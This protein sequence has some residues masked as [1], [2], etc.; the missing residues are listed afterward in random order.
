METVLFFALAYIGGTLGIKLNI[1]AGALLG[2][3][4]FI[5]AFNMIHIV[6]LTS[7]SPL[8]RPMT[9]IALGAMIGLMFT[10]EILKLPIK[11]INSFIF[12]GVGS[13]LSAILIALLFK[14]VGLFPFITG[15]IAVAPGGIAEM[16]TLAYE[17][18]A[19]I[20]VVVMIH[21]IRFVTIMLVLRLLLVFM[22][23]K[24]NVDL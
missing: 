22:K 1:P 24:R 21:I 2:S 13:L 9:K 5:G 15:V 3:M 12:L 6:D 17:V 16:L 10:K 18:D 11:Q 7:I 20:P 4:L 19:D 23:R 8:I 14:L